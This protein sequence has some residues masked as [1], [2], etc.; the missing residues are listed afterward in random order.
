[1]KVCYLLLAAF[2]LAPLWAERTER[3]ALDYSKVRDLGYTLDLASKGTCGVSVALAW[4][5]SKQVSAMRRM[6]LIT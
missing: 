6:R 4:I 3:S 5:N 1:M 2:S